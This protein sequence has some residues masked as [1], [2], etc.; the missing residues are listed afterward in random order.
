MNF[1]LTAVNGSKVKTSLITLEM[2]VSEIMARLIVQMT[3]DVPL[4]VVL[5]PSRLQP[6][7]WSFNEEEL[8][9]IL[10]EIEKARN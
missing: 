10:T 1:I 6:N 8:E 7:Q 5:D 2:T 4:K 9:R 3:N